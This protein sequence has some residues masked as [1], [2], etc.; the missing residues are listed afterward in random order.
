M[1][2][3]G[4]QDRLERPERWTSLS[5]RSGLLG[6]PISPGC[7]CLDRVPLFPQRCVEEPGLGGSHAV[8]SVS[9]VGRAVEQNLLQFLHRAAVDQDRFAGAGFALA[10]AE[11]QSLDVGGTEALAVFGHVGHFK[12]EPT[13]PRGRDLEPR[14]HAHEVLAGAGLE[15]FLQRHLPLA[16]QSWVKARKIDQHAFLTVELPAPLGIGAREARLPET[17]EGRVLGG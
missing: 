9:L 6:D 14:F 11:H 17:H 13:L 3:V 12:V 16:F 8:A 2:L 15:A 5:C 7:G 1:F 10:P 4:A